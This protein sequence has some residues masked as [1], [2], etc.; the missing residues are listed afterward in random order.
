MGKCVM[1]FAWR[2]EQ[3]T[4]HGKHYDFRCCGGSHT[5]SFAE[6]GISSDRLP[7]IRD[8]LRHS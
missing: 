2:Y 3:G 8:L 7:Y 4:E 6:L 1:N 5:I